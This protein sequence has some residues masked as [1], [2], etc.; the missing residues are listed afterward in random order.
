VFDFYHTERSDHLPSKEP[1]RA[2]ARRFL[3]AWGPLVKVAAINDAKIRMFVETSI[4]RGNSMGYI[5]RNLSV[6][7]A[8]LAYSKLP[9]GFPVKEGAILEKWPH[10]KPKARRKHFEPTDAELAR[11]L[12][13]KL[14]EDLRRWILN[15]MATLGR[16]TAVLELTP[17]QRDRI[18]GLIDLN[19]AGRRQN[20][21]FRPAVKEPKVAR[22][23]LNRW[24]GKGAKAMKTDARY[25]AYAGTD[26]LDSAILRA[27][28]PDKANIPRF[29]LYAI[30]HRGTTVLRAAKVP[31]DQIDYQLGHVQGGA[32]TTQDYGQFEP[33][34]LADAARALDVWIRRVLKLAEG[35]PKKP[36]AKT[37]KTRI[38]RH[39]KPLAA[40]RAA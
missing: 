12:R 5:S 18:H 20:K 14:P 7:A 35:R 37:R 27:C 23:W 11:L 22:A 4:K 16:P 34:Y 38:A 30:R 40:R 6:L 29:H 9:V 31:K 25:C 32:R 19:P 24:E 26:S 33:G 2:A 13:Q 1:A 15:A 8:A 28:A 39:A 36:S 10:L 17:A 3:Q 21:K